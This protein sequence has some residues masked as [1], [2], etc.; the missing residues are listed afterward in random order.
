M[1]EVK[2]KR[3]FIYKK[4]KTIH[5]MVKF[6]STVIL[7]GCH[8]VD[9]KK[10]SAPQRQDTGQNDLQESLVASVFLYPRSAW[11]SLPEP[12]LQEQNSECWFA[13]SNYNWKEGYL[14]VIWFQL[15]HLGRIRKSHQDRLTI[16]LS[17]P[18]KT[19][20]LPRPTLHDF[21]TACSWEV[22]NPEEV[23]YHGDA[24]RKDKKFILKN[25]SLK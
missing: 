9:R 12:S 5:S 14:S 1:G 21:I 6:T 8:L 13:T 16:Q 15:R 3:C 23:S 18:M 2:N 19:A 11:L 24:L 10:M 4:R 22:S 7:P 25:K 20:C 17:A